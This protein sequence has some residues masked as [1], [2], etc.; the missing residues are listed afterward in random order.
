VT[1]DG[2]EPRDLRSDAVRGLRWTAIARPIVEIVLLGSMVV[3]ARL[4]PPAEFGRFAVAIVVQEL[5][6]L[7]LAEGVSKALVQRKTVTRQHLQA[8]FALALLAGGALG[9]LTLLLAEVAITPLFGERTAGFVRLSTPLFLIAAV[10][11]VSIA[12]LQRRLA[13]RTLSL[14]DISTT[15]TRAVGSVALAFAGFDGEALV[16][17]GLMGGLSLTAMAWVSAPPPPPRLYRSA[18]HDILEYGVPAGLA[19]VSWVGFRNCDYLIIGARLGAGPAGLYLRAYTLAIEY[20]KKVSLVLGQVGF[21]LL[22]RTSSDEEMA[23]VRGQMVHLLTV[24][25]FPLLAVLA[26]VAPVLVPWLFGPVWAPAVVPTQ[27]LAVGGAATL[28][29]DAVGVV[30]MATGRPRALLGYGVA[31]FIAYALAV[32]V[33]APLGLAAVAG[34][35]AVVHTA[36]LVVAYVLLFS[37]SPERPLRRLCQDI[38]PATISSLA[39]LAV[40]APASVALSAAS[41]PPVVH[42]AVVALAGAPAY[43]LTLRICFPATWRNLLG[44]V[45]QLLPAHPL[46]AL[47]WR[48]APAGQRSGT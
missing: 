43:M 28:V 41:T 9:A 36:F 48:V 8:G 26:V 11:T 25:L 19:S 16:L 34:G 29:I 12:M 3:L 10:S 39:L 24:A 37:G 15:V 47:P 31:H 27:I 4:I 17:G 21:P 7:V 23:A 45:R 40:A 18:V 44:F 46:R 32:L 38:A 30:L 33:L 22:A 20:Q 13:F 1:P 35:A 6:A 5:S 42:I 2:P 14:I